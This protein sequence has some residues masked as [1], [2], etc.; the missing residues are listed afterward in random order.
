[1]NP[2]PKILKLFRVCRVTLSYFSHPAT[3][4]EID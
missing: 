3:L 2:I 1:M 4:A